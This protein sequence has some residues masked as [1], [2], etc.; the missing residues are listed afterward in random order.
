MKF[1]YLLLMIIFAVSAKS[2]TF[3]QTVDL[4]YDNGNPRD[5][6]YNE[7]REWWEES[8]A[9]VPDGPCRITG[10][11][12]YYYGDE[13][14]K[15][16]LRLCWLPISGN[17]KPTQYVWR[18]NQLTDPIE[19]EYNGEPGWYSVDISD[20]NVH[21]DGY[22]TLIV[23][24]RLRP[25]GPWFGYDDD[26]K[27]G[28]LSWMT[29]PFTPNPNFLNIIG[30]IYAY[31]AGDYMVRL[32][33]EYDFPE[34]MS[35][36]EPPAPTLLQ[37]ND[38]SGLGGASA[39][40]RPSVAD[41]N[42]DGWDDIEIGG[43]FFENSGD[44]RFEQV[45]FDITTGNSS[46]GDVNND[47]MPDLF[48]QKGWT[49]DKIYLNHGS[50]SFTDI[51]AATTIVN[52]HPT[53]TPVWMDY[54]GDGLLDLFIANNRSGSWPDE[55]YHPD[56]LFKNMGGN[57]FENV[58]QSSGIAAGEGSGLD[59]YG[60]QPADY[61]NDGLPDIFVANYRLAKDNLYKNNGDGTF[62]EV[63]AQTGVRGEPTAEPQ[64]FG[65]GMGAQWADFNND[66]YM[67]LVVGN[68]AHF[69]S[70]GAVSNPSLIYKNNGPPDWDFEDVHFEMG[71]KPHEGNAGS[72]WLDLNN[73][74]YL[75]LWHGNYSGGFGKVYMNQGPPDW[76]L[77][78][79]TWHTR[80][81]TDD[82]W[83]AARLDFD[84]DGDLDLFQE[85]KL[86]RN[87]M[88][89]SGR[90][91]A[92]RV[93]GDPGAAEGPVNMDAYGTKVIVHA[94]G[95]TY[96]RELSG[97]AAGSHTTQNSNELHFGIGDADMIDKV[98]L[99]YPNGETHE[100][101]NVEPLARYRI[102]YKGQPEFMGIS[103]P[104]IRE[105]KNFSYHTGNVPISCHGVKGANYY[106]V[107]L[108]E[109]SDFSDLLI[110]YNSDN[111]GD[112]IIEFDTYRHMSCNKTYIR[113][114]A[115][116]ESGDSS[117][118]STYEFL[119]C[120]P[121]LSQF[122]LI[123]PA[124]ASPDVNTDPRFRWETPDFNW[125]Y[126][127]GEVHYKI[128]L[129]HSFNFQDTAK[130]FDIINGNAEYQVEERLE[131]G[132]EYYWKV[133]AMHPE[134]STSESSE[135]FSF[136]TVALPNIPVL[137]KP[138]NNAVNVDLKP[139]LEWEKI[140][141]ADY[142]QVQ[143]ARD[144]Q[145]SDMVFEFEHAALNRVPLLQK[146]DGNTDYYWHVRAHNGAGASE[147][148]DTWKFT[149]EDAGDVEN[150]GKSTVE[151]VSISPNPAS[152]LVSFTF[153]TIDAGSAKLEIYSTDGIKIADVFNSE[154][155]GG[156]HIVDW[157]ADELSSGV[158]LCRLTMNGFVK[159]MKLVIER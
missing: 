53:M 153:R 18:F 35:S 129:S 87:D 135:I 6:A 32:K 152:G 108:S 73:D 115:K 68:L 34:G 97:S 52:D 91:V 64:Y 150:I 117:I 2:Q 66:T 8:A 123:E 23:Q 19:I 116:D 131:Q 27:Q 5:H 26:G 90:W 77:K 33:V 48:I 147:W 137:T 86:Y 14:V 1:R 103:A 50:G 130:I 105:P 46:W 127:Q 63:G 96:T 157:Q 4:Q 80:A 7:N 144:G 42:S 89:W 39:G 145:F 146:L 28:S 99:R 83:V 67:D 126:I 44:G 30:T 16:T 93:E 10:I 61:N 9:F 21:S 111:I 120:K 60:A 136:I 55:I 100:I 79:V 149:T 124:N 125:P 156:T 138:E 76:K 159:T 84:H 59:C 143:I 158:Y 110:E 15:D 88:E 81:K 107:Q 75:D 29:D 3:A 49:N 40:G 58:T 43:K 85:G 142:Y 104:A 47:G 106:L 38:I 62:D 11:D 37:V 65:H 24:H 141:N 31:P 95:N 82:P 54:N 155:S 25:S 151:F 154:I 122:D 140:P 70:R 139:R 74:G 22:D 121:E 57:V 41:W 20:R 113:I 71:L 17:L 118:S 101:Q 119:P 94:G 72:C 109:E 13:A 36:L 69:D 92:F 12:V 134:A 78:D 132:R 148:S 133:L 102:P 98:E 128:I 56:Q 112:F 45:N 51:T 114:I